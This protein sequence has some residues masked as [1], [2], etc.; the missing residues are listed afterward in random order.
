MAAKLPAGWDPNIYRLIVAGSRAYN[1]DPAAV[2]AVALG[3]GG[4]RAG[5]VGDNNTSFGPFQLHIGGALPKGKTPEW[6]SSREGIYYALRQMAGVGAAGLTG[7]KAI[8]T[9][10]RKFE[11]PA[12]PDASVTNAVGR[13]DDLAWISGSEVP[14]S[15]PTFSNYQSNA[16]Q[17][18]AQVVNYLASMQP[19]MRPSQ[20]L[21]AFLANQRQMRD[22]VDLSGNLEQPTTGE[23]TSFSLPNGLVSSLNGKLP[24]HSEFNVQDAE[25][26]PGPKGRY[27]A[28]LDWFGNPGQAVFSPWAGRIVEVKP[29]RGNSGQIFGGVVKVQYGKDGPVFVARHVDPGKFSVGQTIAAGTRIGGITDW[30]GGGDHAHIEIWK[31][32]RGGY[33]YTNML[34]PVEVFR[35]VRR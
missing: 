10:I 31:T 24:T 18:R 11:R 3:E 6:A 16:G 27:H 19:G 13:Y 17:A 22:M 28:A 15:V 25:G 21:A 14:A 9:I 30:T 32:L 20:A 23:T 26:A 5:G 29:S 4:I 12:R 34:D 8:D 1:L 33:N 35:S 7:D 2:I